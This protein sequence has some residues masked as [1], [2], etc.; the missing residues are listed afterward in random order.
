MEGWQLEGEDLLEMPVVKQSDCP[1]YNKV[2]VPRVLENQLDLHLESYIVD[3]ENKSL[4]MLQDALLQKSRN[5]PVDMFLSA[6]LSLHVVE[7]DI[8]RL[9]FWV[10]HNQQVSIL[11]VPAL[12]NT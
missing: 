8:W 7:R 2:P 11:H 3:V 1:L 4:K 6:V 9:L 10:Y 12:W 5:S